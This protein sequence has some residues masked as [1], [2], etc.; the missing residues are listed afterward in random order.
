MRPNKLRTALLALVVFAAAGFVTAGP[1]SAAAPVGR[2]QPGTCRVLIDVYGNCTGGVA[3]VPSP[4]GTREGVIVDRFR[5]RLNGRKARV[6]VTAANC[7]DAG[8][9]AHIFQAPVGVAVYV[10]RNGA[11]KLRDAEADLVDLGEFGEYFGDPSIVR[12]GRGRVMVRVPSGFMNMGIAGT[13]DTYI[14]FG[15]VALELLT[16]TIYVETGGNNLGSGCVPADCYEYVTT[17]SY[18]RVA[19]SWPTIVVRFD[20]NA[21]DGSGGV[22]DVTADVE[23]YFYD[24][25]AGT[26]VLEP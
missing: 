13:F 25:G 18:E 22:V 10:R 23:R 14:G 26:Y 1:T 17:T 7:V 8:C 24:V 6:V 12:V 5:T 16:V 9:Q 2:A 21:P 15:G 11:W 3:A 20:G 4:E 19:G